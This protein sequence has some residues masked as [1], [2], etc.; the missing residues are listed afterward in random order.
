MRADVILCDHAEVSGNKLFING[1][2][3]DVMPPSGALSALALII[4]VPWDMTNQK[5]KLQVSLVDDDGRPFVPPSPP[6]STANPLGFDIEFE[7]GRPAGLPV[8]GHVIMPLAINIPLVPMP[9]GK[10]FTWLVRW[11]DIEL[12]RASFRVAAS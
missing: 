2:A 9:P 8:G 10:S 6:G 12:G 7:V 1:A 5:R 3:W 11:D 4:H